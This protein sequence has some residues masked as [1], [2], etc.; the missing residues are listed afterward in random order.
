L[1]DDEYNDDSTDDIHTKR[2][3]KDNNPYIN[4]T[5]SEYLDGMTTE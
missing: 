4:T 2:M 5:Y 3:Q 1:G